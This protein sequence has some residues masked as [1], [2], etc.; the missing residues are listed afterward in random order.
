MFGQKA[1]AGDEVMVTIM[2]SRT[3]QVH[4]LERQAQFGGDRAQF[5]SISGCRF[6]RS[7]A[8]TAAPAARS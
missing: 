7:P 3:G 8:R 5:R 1:A 2:A 6:R 4:R